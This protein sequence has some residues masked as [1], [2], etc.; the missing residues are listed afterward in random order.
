MALQ[1]LPDLL[2][3]HVFILTGLLLGLGAIAAVANGLFA[4]GLV[5]LLAHRVT[6]GIGEAAARRRGITDFGHFIRRVVNLIVRSGLVFGFALADPKQN[7]LAAAFLL[8]A[9]I[10]SAASSLAS[11]IMAAKQNRP[12][13][14][15]KG[16]AHHLGHLAEEGGALL[17]L[18]ASCLVPSA[19]PWLAALLGAIGWLATADRIRTAFRQFR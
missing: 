12:A 18:G 15:R 1:S 2:N 5:L 9:L 14:D 19:F 13:A 4:T 17:A 10:G 11:E 6:D 8:F 16:A 7:A 3:E